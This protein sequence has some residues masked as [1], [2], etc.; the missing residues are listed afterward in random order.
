MQ[1]CSI[2]EIIKSSFFSLS[3][4]TWLMLVLLLHIVIVVFT[5]I[6]SNNY[7]ITYQLMDGVTDDGNFGASFYP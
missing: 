1:N 4:L 5:I 2:V 6:Q 7:S 3:H